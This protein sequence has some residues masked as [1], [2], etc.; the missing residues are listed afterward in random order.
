[1][2]EQPSTPDDPRQQD[3]TDPSQET[4]QH[5]EEP[6][7]DQA[8]NASTG[9][10]GEATPNE[11]EAREWHRQAQF[12]QEQ[13]IYNFYGTTNA[14]GS[15]FGYQV[16]SSIRRMASKLS[17][18]EVTTQLRYFVPTT[19]VSAAVT[20]LS[21]RHLVVLR[22]AEGSGK[23]TGALAILRKVVG[24]SQFVTS[25]PPSYT[26][27]DLADYDRYQ[28]GHGYVIQNCISECAG[29]S[30]QQ[31]DTDQ[32]RRKLM[33]SGAYLVVVGNFGPRD[34]HLG[35]LVV[36]WVRPDPVEVFD[37]R[38][39]VSAAAL[40]P[41]ERDRAYERV[42]KLPQLRDVVA[43]A[44]RILAG[45]EV[46]TAFQALDAAEEKQVTAWFDGKH[47]TR[48]ILSVTALA[49][50]YRIP[51]L[52]FQNMLARL[53]ELYEAP[54]EGIP[55][56][57]NRASITDVLPQCS[58]NVADERA[59]ALDEMVRV[60][61]DAGVGERR[62]R[63]KSDHYR[64]QV[65]TELTER[66]G[67]ELWVPLRKWITEAAKLPSAEARQQL[68]LGVA[69]MCRH[70]P[71]E[72]EWLLEQ[73]A[74]GL[75]T[76]RL[77]ATY[78]L[79]W[80]CVPNL[81]LDAVALQ[82]TVRWTV[83]K[84]A[85]RATTAAMAFGGA[86]GIRYQS[87][88]LRQLW[89]LVLRAES[90]SKTAGE[91]MAVLLRAAVADPEGDATVVDFLCSELRRLLEQHV[92]GRATD[93]LYRRIRKALSAVLTVL[94]VFPDDRSAE[95]MTAV[96]LRTWP[97]ATPQLGKL[98]AEVLRSA[99]HRRTAIDALRD[100]LNA[101]AGDGSSRNAV[102]A[103]GE[104]VRTHLSDEDCR[105][106]HRNLATA[107]AECATASPLLATTLLDALRASQR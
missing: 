20:T 56:Q 72:V 76:E 35:S 101:L 80:M 93:P 82:I 40:E 85:R 18:T 41:A 86:L 42:R 71:D 11:A 73:W 104:A 33:E 9:E 13:F 4:Q 94:S 23:W 90:V 69:L 19:S 62:R 103:L 1:M 87:E 98:W 65:I 14:Q 89:H 24:E 53:V 84:G 96:I 78:V 44:E 5:T 88:V 52:E 105:I 15:Q 106:L 34:R 47:A 102:R 92:G 25:L 75:A 29:G 54:A 43:F 99:P 64:E 95:P 8:D 68:A 37:A 45:T 67:F 77:T 7:P 32:L 30:V 28:R 22:G 36:D 21:E 39:R 31:F 3:G 26:I 66:Y 58:G 2:T 48:E 100:T 107:L 49:F 60:S 6:L 38:L 16:S 46:D 61:G 57:T 83:N 74:D 51:E 55:R 10:D 27:A 97:A 17:S 81:L 59:L 63:F 70:A 79:S 12:V 91:A 50:L